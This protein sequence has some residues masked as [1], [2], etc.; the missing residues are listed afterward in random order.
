MVV[1]P[2]ED[3]RLLS[4]G[5]TVD[6]GDLPDNYGT[7]VLTDGARHEASGP[8]LGATRDG[9]TDG[10]P[11]LGADGDDTSGVAD[12]DGVTFGTIQV[13][14]LD[15][16]ATVNV[17]NAPSGAKLD[18]WIDFNQDGSFGGAGEQVADTVGVVEG[19]NVIEFDVP[20]WA[21][22][23]E[24]YARFRLSSAGDLGPRGA[25]LDGEVEDYG[26]A[27][28]APAAR[29]GEFL[30]PRSVTSPEVTSVYAADVDGDGDMDILSASYAADAITWYE[31]DGH[32]TVTAHP[33]TTDA[34]GAESVFAADMDGDGDMDVLSASYNDDKIAWYENTGFGSFVDHTITTLADGALEVLAADVDGD[35]DIDVLSASAKDDRIAW[36][37]NDGHEQFEPHT[38][39]VDANTPYSIATTD[40]DG[41]GD[42]DV[43][44]A[45]FDDDTIAWYEN[46]GQGH[47]SAH[48]ITTSADGAQ[49]VRA[50][51]IDGDGDTDV[52]SASSRDNTIAW[53]END[54]AQ[55]FTKRNVSTSVYRPT[56]IFVG[57]VDGD[58]DLDVLSGSVGSNAGYA[59]VAWHENSGEEGFVRHTISRASVTRSV[60]AADLD[61]DGDPD[62]LSASQHANGVRWYEQ[63][64]TPVVDLGRVTMAE[65]SVTGLSGGEIAYRFTPTR[66][67]SLVTIDARHDPALGNVSLRLVDQYWNSI[68]EAS[69]SNGLLRI[70]YDVVQ[71]GQPYY[72]IVSGTNPSVDLR[73]ADLVQVL[74]EDKKVVA[75][76]S[77]AEDSY[78]FSVSDRFDVSVNGIDYAFDRD[79][80]DTFI[81]YGWG[82]AA[83]VLHGTP[84]AEWAGLYP[85]YC[86]MEATDA[87]FRV[88]AH[89]MGSVTVIGGGG[90]DRVGIFDSSGNDTLT[91]TPTEM[92]LRGT[93]GNDRSFEI[94]AVGFPETHA[95]AKN[96]G[97]DTA[98][99]NGS[100]QSDLFK[101]YHGRQRYWWG[102]GD[103][104]VKVIG[105]G[106]YMR[107]KFFET[108]HVDMGGGF[109]R[110][111][112]NPSDK[113]DVVWAMKDDLRVD[114]DVQLADGETPAFASM[115][116]GVTATGWERAYARA[117]G[118][119]DW[120]EL[121]DSSWNDVL[122]AR[123]HKVEMM[124]AAWGRIK[125][126]A[127]YRICARG[128][129]NV[130]AIADQG[131]SKDIAKLYDSG[132]EG[133]DVWAAGY[134]DGVTWSSMSSP[135]RLLYEALAFEYVG[136]Y[137]FNGGLGESHGTNRKDF[138]DAV[139]FLF[140]YGYWEGEEAVLPGSS[141]RPSGRGEH[142]GR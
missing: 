69:E 120:I 90:D 127:E 41:D 131:G 137:G 117:N 22:S 112:V 55:A 66:S 6:F 76:G 18:A 60:H 118:P 58:G 116:Y 78:S 34:D 47:F 101:A 130:S 85:D 52:V 7:T 104:I 141:G 65:V 1:E 87:S 114:Y 128:F 82:D 51:D 92:A 62:V 75:F 134:V 25:A 35:G 40:V 95:Y 88:E 59:T 57:D 126:G 9:E 15:A 30:S 98:Y 113:V 27:L 129:Q 123:P 99:L 74:P 26:V 36:Y 107:T 124:N 86:A 2:L 71:G 68:A 4:V 105:D 119:D 54:G 83:A 63:I 142:A 28:A 42:I 133:V 24:T 135:T 121:H 80:F 94:V 77:H 50:A 115:S 13:G 49:S 108:V 11:T 43:L 14:Q 33:I 38:I 73:V 8:T 3:R 29:E 53:Y 89:D 19:D 39:A 46:D 61:G 12:E 140:Q 106:Y 72:T 103:S 139:D 102:S 64:D 136:G 100:S 91:A 79:A 20:S 138:S 16:T 23:G 109:D 111:V 122:I 132:D 56:C 84:G 17:Q 31:N 21:V 125:R 97:H 10:I 45:S 37:E 70:D 81:F 5:G 96:G 110:A 93:L 44:S 67:N 48:T 32:E